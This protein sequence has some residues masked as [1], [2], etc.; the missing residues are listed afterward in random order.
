MKTIYEYDENGNLTETALANG[1]ATSYE[2]NSANMIDS[3]TTVNGTTAL[4]SGSYEYF[5][6]GNMASKTENNNITAYTYDLQGRLTTETAPASIYSYSYDSFGNRASMNVLDTVSSENYTTKCI[7][8][9]QTQI[10]WVRKQNMH[11]ANKLCGCEFNEAI[12]HETSFCKSDM[13]H[14]ALES[15]SI[16]EWG[17]MHIAGSL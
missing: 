11:I 12:A 14:S 17:T 13:C 2:Y 1:V 16:N 8:E 9:E 5:L 6:D 4:F 3:L 10:A 15:F 7:M